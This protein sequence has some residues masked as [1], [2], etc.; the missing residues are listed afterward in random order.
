MLS[1]IHRTNSSVLVLVT[2]NDAAGHRTNL[3][4]DIDH[5]KK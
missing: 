5:I 4:T 3:H 1:I 2:G